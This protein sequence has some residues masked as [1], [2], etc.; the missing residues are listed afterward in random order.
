MIK[1][2]QTQRIPQNIAAAIRRR[3]P[4][5]I[6]DEFPTDES[7]FH[8]IHAK[9]ERGLRKIREASLLWQT[10]DDEE[11]ASLDGPDDGPPAEAWQSYHVFFLAPDGDDFHVLGETEAIAEPAE[12]EEHAMSDG[13]GATSPGEEWTGYAVGISLVAR[14]AVINLGCYAQYEDGTVMTPDVESFIYSDIT[15]ERIDALQYYQEILGP[16]AFETL[17]ALGDRIASVLRKHRIR[18]LPE[19]VLNLYVPGLTTG[20]GVFLEAPLRVRDA[21]FFRGI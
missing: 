17:T 10:A 11:D 14:Y 5:G 12:A 1:P 19:S 3:F 15:G 13:P 6:V 9:V 4:D 16:V 20:P 18:V 8:A 21:L 2:A 7:Y